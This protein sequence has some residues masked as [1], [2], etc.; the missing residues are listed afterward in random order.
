[1]RHD[2]SA[3]ANARHSGSTDVGQERGRRRSGGLRQS[4]AKE[5]SHR[6]LWQPRPSSVNGAISLWQES[7]RMIL[8]VPTS[9]TSLRCVT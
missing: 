2:L 8:A 7:G 1:V 3:S 6:P 5:A 9:W 4:P